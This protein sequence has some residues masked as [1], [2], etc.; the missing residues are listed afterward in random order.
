VFLHVILAMY[1]FQYEMKILEIIITRFSV[2]LCRHGSV[3][4]AAAVR[5]YN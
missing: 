3:L 1:K 4:L 2:M 5:I